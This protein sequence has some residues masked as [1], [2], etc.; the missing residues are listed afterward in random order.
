MPNN[1]MRFCGMSSG[2]IDVSLQVKTTNICFLKIEEMQIRAIIFNLH[3]IAV[4]LLSAF[5]TG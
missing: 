1:V 2:I 3:S 5:F 4:S